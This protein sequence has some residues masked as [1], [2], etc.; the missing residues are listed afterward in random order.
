MNNNHVLKYVTN[1][2]DKDK[3]K[4]KLNEYNNTEVERHLIDQNVYL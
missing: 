4:E 3:E 2:K 1:F